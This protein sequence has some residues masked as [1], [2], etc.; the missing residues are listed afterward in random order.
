M[1]HR[2]I[3]LGVQGLA[4]TFVLMDIPF[5]SEEAKKVNTLIF[6]TIYHA[7]LEKS[8][9]IAI[10]IKESYLSKVE[11]PAHTVLYE[12]KYT[13]GLKHGLKPS[14]IGAYQSFEDSPASKGILQFDMWGVEPTPN[15]YD[16]D[17]LKKS[18]V[19]K[20]ERKGG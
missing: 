20:K 6:E 19:E 4:D 11:L 18:I 7:A 8:N 9:E 3:G 13:N 17:A 10:S 12:M 1:L 15:R 5:H 16:W 2:P 14:H